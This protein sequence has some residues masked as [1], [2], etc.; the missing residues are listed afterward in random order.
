M[1][2][3]DGDQDLVSIVAGGSVAFQQQFVAALAAALFEA[4]AADWEAALAGGRAVPQRRAR[5]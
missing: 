2:A 1:R 4:P 3:K 5:R